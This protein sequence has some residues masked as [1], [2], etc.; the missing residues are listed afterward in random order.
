M[1][2]GVYLFN[3]KKAVKEGRSHRRGEAGWQ[4]MHVPVSETVHMNGGLPHEGTGGATGQL[5]RNSVGNTISDGRLLHF[6]NDRVS[7]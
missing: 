7:S 2:R 4:G 1:L 3:R 5:T 6:C